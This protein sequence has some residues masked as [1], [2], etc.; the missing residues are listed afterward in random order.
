MLPDALWELLYSDPHIQKM[1][2][3]GNMDDD[4]LCKAILAANMPSE[5]MARD[6]HKR[7][8]E[9]KIPVAQTV[10]VEK[11]GRNDPRPCGSGKKYKKCCGRRQ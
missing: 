9:I 6:L 4:E 7:F 2:Q 3:T 1:I 5:S 10:K 8:D 11:I